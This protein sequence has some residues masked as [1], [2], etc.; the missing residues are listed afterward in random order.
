MI[1]LSIRVL[2]V[3][4]CHSSYWPK[5]NFRGQFEKKVAQVYNQIDKSISRSVR[6][7]LIDFFGAGCRMHDASDRGFS[8]RD[9][10]TARK[11]VKINGPRARGEMSFRRGAK[12][13]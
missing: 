4:R 11:R 1:F 7:L 2:F 13:G 10:R 3:E 9:S 12:N 5:T 8:S 6:F